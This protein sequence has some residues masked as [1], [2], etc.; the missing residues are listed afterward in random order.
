MEMLVVLLTIS[1]LATTAI[2]S[3]AALKNPLDDGTN[4]T[5]SI[6]KQARAKAI[7]TTSA[8]K[9]SPTSNNHIKAE[10]LKNCSSNSATQDSKLALDMPQGVL[11][12][13]TNWSICFDS[14]GF[15]QEAKNISL[16]DGSGKTKTLEIYLGGAVR[17]QPNT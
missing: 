3:L 15:A 4:I 10:Y 11:L 7:A 16:Y 2:P 9:I 14:R 6:L 17:I 12:G 8:Y 5:M 13:A 1:L